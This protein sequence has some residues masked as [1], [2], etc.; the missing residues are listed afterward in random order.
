[1]GKPDVAS[2]RASAQQ[3]ASIQRP[4]LYRGWGRTNLHELGDVELGR[5]ERLHLADENVLERVDRLA[6]LHDER[7]LNQIELRLPPTNL[8]GRVEVNR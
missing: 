4:F 2:T 6:R 8:R 1:M 3:R 5:L 7:G